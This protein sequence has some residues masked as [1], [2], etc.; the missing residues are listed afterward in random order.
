MRISFTTSVLALTLG[1]SLVERAAEAQSEPARSQASRSLEAHLRDQLSGIE[2]GPLESEI[3]ALGPD[4]SAPLI[5]IASDAQ[6]LPFLRLRAITCLGWVPGDS[7]TTF[8]QGVLQTEQEPMRLRAAIRSYAGR[9][10]TR[11]LTAVVAHGA[12]SDAVVREAVYLSLIA[13]LHAEP[14]RAQQTQ[15]TQAL[16]RLLARESDAELVQHVRTLRAAS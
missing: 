10:G 3:R 11:A 15:I 7:A 16:D 14:S 2:D 6:A 13:M 8:L 4:A 5:A 12:H 9:E 1:L